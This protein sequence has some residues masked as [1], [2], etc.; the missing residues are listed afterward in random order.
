MTGCLGNVR[1]PLPVMECLFKHWLG[2]LADADWTVEAD[3]FSH[4]EPV[5]ACRFDHVLQCFTSGCAARGLKI[6][7]TA[8]FILQLDDTPRT[9]RPQAVFRYIQTCLESS[10]PGQMGYNFDNV[11]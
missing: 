11:E 4:K 6:L 7:M 3:S 2:P 8:G 10:S 1:Y 5:K 9:T